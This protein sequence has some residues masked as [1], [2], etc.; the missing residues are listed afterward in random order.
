V[1]IC[2]DIRICRTGGETNAVGFIQGE[3]KIDVGLSCIANRSTLLRSGWKI[4]TSSPDGIARTSICE[5]ADFEVLGG[6]MFS[7]VNAAR[8]YRPQM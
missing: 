7:F 4:D 3:T 5:H 2:K 8:A 6:D 1:A